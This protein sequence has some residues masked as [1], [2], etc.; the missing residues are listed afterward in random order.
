MSSPLL[1]MKGQIRCLHCHKHRRGRNIRYQQQARY[2]QSLLL[3]WSRLRPRLGI[4]DI[5]P[6]PNR[7]HQLQRPSADL[8]GWRL[9]RC[10]PGSLARSALR[11]PQ[12]WSL[13]LSLWS[14]QIHCLHNHRPKP[15]S[16]RRSWQQARNQHNLLLH[17]C[18]L[19]PRLGKSGNRPGQSR[20]YQ[21][22]PPSADLPDFRLMRC[23]PGS[24]V[25]S[26]VRYQP[27]RPRSGCRLKH[28]SSCR[29]P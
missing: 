1:V 5:R 24:A 4:F 21:L 8:S 23:R 18:R 3:R 14:E 11:C 29:T 7:L 26:A 15:Y 13:L 19:R 2:Q 17:C 22:P 6:V 16:C 20:Q 12:P 10:R 25:R 9:L 27:F 28:Y